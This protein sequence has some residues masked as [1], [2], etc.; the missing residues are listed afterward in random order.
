MNRPER[1]LN[2]CPGDTVP[3]VGFEIEPKRTALAVTDPQKDFLHARLLES[4]K[5]PLNE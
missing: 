3:E 1:I 2:A 4:G 5:A